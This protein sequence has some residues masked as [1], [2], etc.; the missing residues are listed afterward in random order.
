M[1]LV[2]ENISVAVVYDHSKQAVLMGMSNGDTQW[3]F[4]KGVVDLTDVGDSYTA[5]RALMEQFG[6]MFDAVAPMV[7][8]FRSNKVHQTDIQHVLIM[9]RKAYEKKGT[10]YY[11]DAWYYAHVFVFEFNKTASS[12]ILRS[13][14]NTSYD[15]VRWVKLEDILKL[16]MHEDSII[17][18]NVFLRHLA[19]QDALST[20]QVATL[21]GARK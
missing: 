14:K 1:E 17:I 4:A 13:V 15:K 11:K 8:T 19:E 12:H 20:E 16:R 18:F 7:Y 21:L 2:S 10:T 9:G 5:R 6:M 3:S